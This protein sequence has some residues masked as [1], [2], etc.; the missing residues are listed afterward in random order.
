MDMNNEDTK[1]EMMEWTK[2]KNGIFSWPTV[3]LSATHK[4]CKTQK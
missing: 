2:R 1:E 4:I 3:W